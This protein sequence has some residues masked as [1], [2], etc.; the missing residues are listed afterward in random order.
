MSS[1]RRR[2]RKGHLRKNWPNLIPYS[3][4]T[5]GCLYLDL[6]NADED[7]LFGPLLRYIRELPIPEPVEIEGEKTV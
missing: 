7:G 4:R 3:V 2:L 1:I 6:T 5:K